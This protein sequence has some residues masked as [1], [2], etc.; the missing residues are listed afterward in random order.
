MKK[1][2]LLIIT[3][4]I[5]SL[6][7][8]S[9][10]AEKQVGMTDAQ[11]NSFINTEFVIAKE[12]YEA[13]AGTPFKFTETK[14]VEID[15]TKYAL[16]NDVRYETFDSLNHALKYYFTD[17]FVTEFFNPYFEGA[18]SKYKNIDGKVYVNISAEKNDF[19]ALIDTE[20][21]S[22]EK[23]DGEST[24]VTVE[25]VTPQYIEI[26]GVRYSLTIVNE[27]DSTFDVFKIDSVLH[28]EIEIEKKETAEP[29]YINKSVTREE[30]TTTEET[31]LTDE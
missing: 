4:I 5:M 25:A 8:L 28:E 2:S 17:S 16:I 10:C 24:I 20:T 12:L 21:I 6:N 26:K 27:G 18:S 9:S 23:N 14:T 1:A 22:A 31:D 11:I 19:P 30:T 29:I 7:I 3:I 13:F 15:G